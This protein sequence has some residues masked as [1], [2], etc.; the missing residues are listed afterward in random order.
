MPVSMVSAA[1]KAG[2]PFTRAQ[3]G[4]TNEKEWI[5]F[6]DAYHI[7][8]AVLPWAKEDMIIHISPSPPKRCAIHVQKMAIVVSGIVKRE[9]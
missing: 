5:Q 1:R 4:F 7:D 9:R 6:K 8:H 3:N 2:I